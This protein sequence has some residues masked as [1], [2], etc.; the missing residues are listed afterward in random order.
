MNRDRLAA[1]V[2][3]AVVVGCRSS[4]PPPSTAPPTTAAPIAD[5]AEPAS[6][7]EP[8]A[9]EPAAATAPEPAADPSGMTPPAIDDPQLAAL[10]T[11]VRVPDLAALASTHRRDCKAFAPRSPC[12]LKLDLDGDG[13]L[14]RTFKIRSTTDPDATGI[15]IAWAD[16]SVS[17]IAAGAA[18]RQLWTDPYEGNVDLSW[19]EVEPDLGAEGWRVAKPVGDGYT[20]SRR[21][22][23]PSTQ[24]FAPGRAGAGIWLDGTDA[25]EILYWDRE[26][27]RRLVVGF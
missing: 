18:S 19:H 20:V 3:L 22:P 9:P 16:A 2:S 23:N 12:E 13:R 1:C 24:L 14:E 8:P 6:P 10:P 4:A 11:D 25:A 5:P 27:W 17:I 26:R 21:G 15:A 7:P